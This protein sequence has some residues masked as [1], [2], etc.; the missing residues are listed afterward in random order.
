MLRRGLESGIITIGE[1]DQEIINVHV[2]GKVEED[3]ELRR[4]RNPL[5]RLTQKG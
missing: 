2:A 4:Q 5:D 1:L 3:A